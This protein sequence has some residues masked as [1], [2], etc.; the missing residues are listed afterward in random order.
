MKGLFSTYNMEKMNSTKNRCNF[1]VDHGFL[2]NYWRLYESDS[3]KILAPIIWQK[4]VAEK[5]N[6]FC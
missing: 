1:K 3:V 2:F 6:S 4:E 5:L